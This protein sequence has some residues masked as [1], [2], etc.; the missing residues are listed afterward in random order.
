MSASGTIAKIRLVRSLSG[1]I[2]EFQLDLAHQ[3][4]RR[5][6]PGSGAT[7][8]AAR[9]L[10]ELALLV[11]EIERRLPKRPIA[12]RI[13]RI[14]VAVPLRDP[15]LW[16]PSASAALAEILQV[17]GNVEW[18][19]DFRGRDPSRSPTPLDSATASI[20][21]PDRSAPAEKLVLFSGGLD[22]T[23]GLATLA[24]SA[25]RTLAFSFYNQWL[26]GKQQRILQALGF[27]RHIQSYGAFKTP[28]KRSRTG[29]AFN[30]RSFLFL[31]LAAIEAAAAGIPE[32]VQFENGPLALAVPP[33][34]LFRV[35]RHAH[36][37]VQQRAAEL[38]SALLGAPIRIGNPFLQET[39]AEAVAELRKLTGKRFRSIVAQTESCWYPKATRVIGGAPKQINQACG[40][41]IPCLVRATALK[42]DDAPA[43]VDFTDARHPRSDP[44]ERFNVDAYLDFAD[45]V[46]APGYGAGQLLDD[47][48]RVTARALLHG[49]AGLTTAQALALYKRFAKE[50]RATFPRP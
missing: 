8:A 46:L 30:H 31:S 7:T 42:G 12:D 32:V 35:T 3:K 34:P 18:S 15:T 9:D 48:P 19:F 36:P 38:F 41:C 28:G 20:P 14:D 37:L 44:V 11:F 27:R 40:A 43:A 4:W 39:K 16:T 26:F 23:A 29:G 49:E 22:S 2:Q 17:Q 1:G 6:G 33:A 25:D 47:A 24:A 45:R 10:A 5:H 21:P 13:G 50:L